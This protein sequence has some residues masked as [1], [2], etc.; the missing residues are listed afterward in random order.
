[1]F[2]TYLLGWSK[3]NKFYYGVRYSKDA[4]PSELWCKY[5]TSSKHVKNFAKKNGDPDIVQVRKTFELKEAAIDWEN[6]VL[7][8]MKVVQDTRFLNAT[9][10]KAIPIVNF[11]R[12]KNLANRRPYQ[13]WPEESKER[14]REGVRNAARRNWANGIYTGA[15][16]CDPIN[17]KNAAMERWSNPD[18]K[19][20]AKSRK[21]INNGYSSKMIPAPELHSF[22][23]SGWS[24]GRGG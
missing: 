5:K 10:N 21:W 18:F 2:Y 17:Y 3:H 8:R 22:L 20:K 1:M 9:D 14:L 6:K 11:D 24:L 23:S 19:A 16:N 4:D 12:A 15:K 7:K 13:E